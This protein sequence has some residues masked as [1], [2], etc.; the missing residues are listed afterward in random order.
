LPRPE[1][2]CATDKVRTMRR[3][4]E[5]VASAVLAKSDGPL[6]QMLVVENSTG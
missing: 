4:V 1:K 3:C 6:G 5:R 2:I